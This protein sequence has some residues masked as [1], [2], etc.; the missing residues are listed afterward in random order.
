MLMV[1][2]LESLKDLNVGNPPVEESSNG[3][4]ELERKAASQNGQEDSFSSQ[5]KTELVSPSVP[6][7][8]KLP[9]QTLL[10]NPDKVFKCSPSTELENQGTCLPGD[11]STCKENL[12]DSNINNQ[13]PNEPLIV[14]RA[15]ATREVTS[16]SDDTP[17]DD[18]GSSEADVADGT[19]VTLKVVKNPTSNIMDGLL[20]RWDLNFFRNR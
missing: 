6:D 8:D 13:Q 17:S 19:K 16:H 2:V 20:R 3:D 7:Y 10:P 15:E 14:T 5:T 12:P 11:T 9:S 18:Q 1:A 4:S